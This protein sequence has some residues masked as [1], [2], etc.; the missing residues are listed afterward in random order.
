MASLMSGASR[1]R[2]FLFPLALKSPAITALGS[3][4]LPVAMPTIV[5]NEHA[6]CESAES[7]FAASAS[8]S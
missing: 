2:M 5:S 1:R 6:I 4:I 3:V 7:R 8:T